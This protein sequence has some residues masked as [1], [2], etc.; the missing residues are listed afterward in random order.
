M[1]QDIAHP[2]E[3]GYW[4]DRLEFDRA[5]ARIARDMTFE[6]RPV[7]FEPLAA[8]GSDGPLTVACNRYGEAMVSD[9]LEAPAFADR[10][11]RFVTDAVKCRREA[12]WALEPGRRLPA[13]SLADDALQMIS[14]PMCRER[15]M[16]LHRELYEHGQRHGPADG[17]RS[18]H[19]CGDATRHFPALHEALGVTVFDTGFPVDHGALRDRL[20]EG[21]L[22]QGGPPVSLLFGADAGAVYEATRRI[23][24]S[25][26]CRGG[27][28]V[29]REANNLPP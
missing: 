19:L 15:I 16:P 13:R 3:H 1:A 10:T 12:F 5:M 26:V 23:L 17:E 8:M 2:F 9:L 14:V 7:D 22:I 27:R 4:K 21:V 28:F 20:G 18:M 6:G 29:L 24:S 25:G 11:L